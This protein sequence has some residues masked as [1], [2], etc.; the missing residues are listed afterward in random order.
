MVMKFDINSHLQLYDYYTKLKTGLVNGDRIIID[1]N[2]IS[3]FT[4]V[5]LE[6]DLRKRLNIIEGE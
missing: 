4:A 1:G 2:P 3:V 6:S 5:I